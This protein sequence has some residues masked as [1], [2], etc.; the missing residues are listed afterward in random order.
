[1]TAGNLTS[2]GCAGSVLDADLLLAYWRSFL[3]VGCSSARDRPL[4]CW[5]TRRRQATRLVALVLAALPD[6]V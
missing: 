3:E 1:M 2:G 5:Q 4:S 6:D